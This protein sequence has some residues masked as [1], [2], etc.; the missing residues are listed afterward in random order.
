MEEKDEEEEEEEEE[1]KEEKTESDMT[2]EDKCAENEAAVLP[3]DQ[4]G[5]ILPDPSKP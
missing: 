5:I 4:P 1:E 3:N 2:C